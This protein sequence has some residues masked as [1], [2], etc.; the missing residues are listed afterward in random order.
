MPII[1]TESNF[2]N[3][4]HHFLEEPM[5]FL[6]ALK[7]KAKRETSKETDFL[8]LRQKPTQILP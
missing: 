3:L 8:I 4:F 7:W 5:H 1:Q 6:L 2:E